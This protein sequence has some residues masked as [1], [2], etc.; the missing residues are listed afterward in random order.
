[1]KLGVKPTLAELPEAAEVPEEREVRAGAATVRKQ[2]SGNS[3]DTVRKLRDA[4]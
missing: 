1:M 4:N 3:P 2:H